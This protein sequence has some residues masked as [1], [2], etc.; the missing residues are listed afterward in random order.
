MRDKYTLGSRVLGGI[1]KVAKIIGDK[2]ETVQADFVEIANKREQRKREADAARAAEGPDDE[3]RGV[4]Q[5]RQQ[6]NEWSEN[7]G[8]GL[9]DV[10]ARAERAGD[11]ASA[12]VK[13]EA[14]NTLN[15]LERALDVDLNRDGKKGSEPAKDD[16]DAGPHGSS[17]L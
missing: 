4:E 2:A 9:R 10:L 12:G 15:R 3:N 16:S 6:M 8:S 13:R 17:T 7:V 1:S 11:A 14:R 5:F